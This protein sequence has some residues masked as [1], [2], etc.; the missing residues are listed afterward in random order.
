MRSFSLRTRTL[1][2]I[3]I[4]LAALV[5]I[6]L[7]LADSIIERNIRAVEAN[8][9][10]EHV[11]QIANA[12]DDDIASLDRTT[13][14]YATWDETYA[15]AVK[16]NPEYVTNN[17]S[18]STFTNNNLSYVA[19]VNTVGTLVYARAFD[20][21]SQKE[22]PPPSDLRQFAGANA[23]LLQHTDPANK[24]AGL[25]VLSDGPM[26]LSA[27]PILTSLGQGPATGT[28]IMGRRLDEHEVVRLAAVTRLPI[29]VTRL[30]APALS[31]LLQQA[32]TM[33]AAGQIIVT[34]PIDNQHMLGVTRIADLRDETGMLLSVE[35]PR[36]IYHLGQQ[37]NREYTLALLIAGVLFGII[38]FWMLDHTVLAR[39]TRL[40][41]Q[42][43][44]V[45][46]SQ[47][48]AQIT[49]TGRDEISQLGGAINQMLSGLAQAQHQLAKKE[50]RYR[51]LI[52][53]DPDAIIV[54][55]GQHIRYTNPA[56]ARL[57]GG[58]TPESCIGWQVDATINTLA[59]ADN[60]VPVVAERVLTYPDGTTVDAELVVLSF[61][62]HDTTAIQVIVRN[63]T[64]RKQVE[65][66]LR[67]AKEAADAANRAKSQFLAVMSHELR[68]PLTAIIGYAELL[69]LT[70][71]TS[72]DREALHGLDC[73]RSAGTHLLAII[74]NILN[75]S[76]IE[77]G[78]MSVQPAPVKVSS[79]LYMVTD[80]IHTLAERNGNHFEIEEIDAVGEMETDEVHLRQI[81]INL[82]GNACKFT[83]E[84][85]VTLTMRVLPSATGTDVDQIAFV[86]RDTGIGMRSDQMNLLFRD[87]VQVDSST[88]RTYGGT[89][90]GLALSQRLAHLL[91][92]AITVSS[93]FGE[94][95]TFTLTLPRTLG[96]DTTAVLGDPVALLAQPSAAA[97]APPLFDVTQETRIVLVINDEQHIR[98]LLLQALAQPGLHIEIAATGAA[99]LDLAVT[100]MPDLIILDVHLPDRDGWMVLQQL[101]DDPETCTIP[102][103][104]LTVSQGVEQGIV[105]GAAGVLHKPVDT[106]PL[107]PEL[108]AVLCDN[109]QR[110]AWALMESQRHPVL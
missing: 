81:L 37:A 33:I 96:A 93:V 58:N 29:S 42:V 31:P 55:D 12:F 2:G 94:G 77:A 64:E 47:P 4:M 38:V 90:L 28:L 61:H 69:E 45:D 91:G 54:H 108:A 98:T 67:T 85:N 5:G 15:F 74:N 51:Q 3:L 27:R 30:D 17:T 95:S 26:L 49:I 89:G 44:A 76:R 68:T 16:P 56:G 71:T 86:V 66:A 79:M 1:L 105:L 106:N 59:P 63:I 72:A 50:R 19:V 70:L 104:L 100:L 78:H 97:E 20:L 11:Q 83:H 43:A 41:A 60:D 103:L 6:L 36:D 57:L 52:E 35:L 32:A 39:I 101:K 92:G 46:A 82:L 25:V 88:T 75:I 14:D 62:D 8:T 9:A 109:V 102:V 23:R 48:K 73:I 110:S 22:V 107:A 84:G 7:L 24:L 53:L 99:G 87:F 13:N 40:S 10:Q 34:T 18:D 21:A 65:Q 80:T